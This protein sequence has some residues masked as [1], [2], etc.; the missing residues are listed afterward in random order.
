MA[1]NLPAAFNAVESHL[2]DALEAFVA[3]RE[4][5]SYILPAM[6]NQVCFNDEEAMNSNESSHVED[7]S[8]PS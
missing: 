1:L 2:Y 4:T 6:V 5:I 7:I 8:R 3:T